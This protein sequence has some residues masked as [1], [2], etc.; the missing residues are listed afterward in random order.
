MATPRRNTARAGQDDVVERPP[1]LLPL[2]V[3]AGVVVFAAI[4]LWY[5]VGPTTEEILGRAPQAT[6]SAERVHVSIGDVQ[7]AVPA[8]YTRFAAA[9]SGGAL[10]QLDMHALL[11]D[12]T[13]YTHDLQSEFERADP[14]SPVIHM[15][16]EEAAD[17]LAA[18]PRL[19]LI[20]LP[21][22]TNREGEPG[23]AGL[24]HYVFRNDTGLAGQDMYV[25]PGPAGAPAI[26]VCAREA[27]LLW[28]RRDILLSDAVVLRYR[29]KRA[30]LADWK[31]ID[32]RVLALIGQFREK[33]RPENPPEDLR[34]ER[35]DP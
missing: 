31:A 21:H 24:R 34:L 27:P 14:R 18:Q 13:P 16:V 22:V 28:C 23:P 9:R 20:Y 15:R 1:W 11:P 33:A 19:E 17:I 6:D 32:D 5:Y 4:F 7:L 26:L 30:H 12:L 10:K 25:G 3:A 35:A 8:H 29:F 2:L